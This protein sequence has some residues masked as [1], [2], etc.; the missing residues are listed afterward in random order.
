MTKLSAQMVGR[1]GE[2]AVEQELLKRG[3]L[4]GN[5]NANISNAAAYDLFA[6]KGNKNIC[7]RVKTTSGSMVQYNAK[8]SGSAFIDFLLGNDSDYAAIVLMNEEAPQEFYLVPTHI[9]DETLKKANE[10]WLK[11]PKR[12]GSARKKTNHRALDFNG[13]QT[14]SAPHKGMRNR[15]Q[16]YLNNWA[17]A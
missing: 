12:D 14:V 2:L 17:F 10:E 11:H 1:L 15:W 6:V 7:L 4:V 8:K 9:V 3:W 5:F 16:Q 13:K